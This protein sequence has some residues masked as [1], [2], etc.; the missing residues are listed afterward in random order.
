MSKRSCQVHSQIYKCGVQERDVNLGD[1]NIW[2]IFKASSMN[3][4][5]SVVAQ[6]KPTRL[7]SMRLQVGSLASLSGLRIRH[8]HEL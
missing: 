5:V 6:W 1:I 3:E 8:C 4:G 7:V 2:M